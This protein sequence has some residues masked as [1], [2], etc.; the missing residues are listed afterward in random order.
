MRIYSNHNKYLYYQIIVILFVM[1]EGKSK[2]NT[3]WIFYFQLLLLRILIHIDYSK[4][5]SQCQI[6]DIN[7]KPH[8]KY[9][10]LRITVYNP[11]SSKLD[12]DNARPKKPQQDLSYS[13]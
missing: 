13:L 4:I 5:F 12:L 10:S 3:P 8:V 9:R 11:S 7:T 2:G 6:K 1:P